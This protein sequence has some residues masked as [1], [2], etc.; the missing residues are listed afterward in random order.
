[1]PSSNVG[2][3]VAGVKLSKEISLSGEIPLD[4]CTSQYLYQLVQLATVGTCF[5]L[6]QP[7]ILLGYILH[8]RIDSYLLRIV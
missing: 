4:N 5:D 1:M 6:L 3:T 2:L 7:V 8:V